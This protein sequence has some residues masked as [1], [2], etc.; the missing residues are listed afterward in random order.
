M[1]TC[2]LLDLEP[3]G[4]RPVMS[5]NLNPDL[6]IVNQMVKETILELAIISC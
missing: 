6:T 2:D 4:S 3:L 1:S 5:K